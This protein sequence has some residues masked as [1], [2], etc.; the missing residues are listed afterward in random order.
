[1]KLYPY[2]IGLTKIDLKW[3]K[4]LNITPETRNI[5]KH[6]WFGTAWFKLSFAQII[7]F[8]ICLSLS[9]KSSGFRRKNQRRPLMAPRSRHLLNPLSSCFFAAFG[10]HGKVPFR[11]W[12]LAL[13]FCVISDFKKILFFVYFREEGRERRR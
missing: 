4:D 9:V 1:M 2:L 11:S 13:K 10:V 8:L 12:V 3:I 7:L 6:R 5:P